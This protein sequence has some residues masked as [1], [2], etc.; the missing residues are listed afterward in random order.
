[1]QVKNI[2]FLQAG[3]CVATVAAV[4][5][6]HDRVSAME[7]IPTLGNSPVLAVGTQQ[8]R[9]L[10]VPVEANSHE[11]LVSVSHRYVCVQSGIVR[12]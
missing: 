6:L 12:H 3:L 4:S 8:G 1:M 9:V 5:T 10:A 7:F 2:S 11:T